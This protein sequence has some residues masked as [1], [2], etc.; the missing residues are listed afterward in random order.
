[1]PNYSA[2]GA[3]GGPGGFRGGI[4][5]ASP[6]PGQGPG[7][8]AAADIGSDAS[9]GTVGESIDPT[10]RNA[11]W[12]YANPGATYGNPFLIPLIGGS[13]GGGSRIR[14][15]GG[16]SGGGGGGGGGAM[17]IAANGEIGLAPVWWTP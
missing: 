5:G 13:G 6:T 17:L 16:G 9:Y 7:G 14:I 2:S 10:L 12:S 3:P 4:C 1:M 15:H 11:D 8:G